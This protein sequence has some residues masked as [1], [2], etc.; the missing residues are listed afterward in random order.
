MAE[1]RACACADAYAKSQPDFGA[2]GKEDLDQ[3]QSEFNTA[4]AKLEGAK[5]S[6][7][8]FSDPGASGGC[9]GCGTIMSLGN[10]CGC[11]AAL[12][13]HCH[14]NC[15]GGVPK[16]AA[17]HVSTK[18][19]AKDAAKKKIADKAGAKAAHHKPAPVAAPKP[20][21]KAH[22]HHTPAPAPKRKCDPCEDNKV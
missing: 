20:E 3:A 14:G 9:A 5:A 17:P 13:H 18:S 19:A 22:S 10:H 2:T 21:P 8:A 15:G 11:A 1:K 12:G 6:A 7:S 16:P 4:K